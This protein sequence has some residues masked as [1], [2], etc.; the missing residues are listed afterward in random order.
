MPPVRPL[1]S[2]AASA[3]SFALLAACSSLPTIAPD[4]AEAAGTGGVRIDGAH[5]PLS[6]DAQKRVLA[7]LQAAGQDT[8]IF[9][10][11]LAYE[12]EIVGSP[13][14]AGNR[15]TLLQDGPSTYQALYA[16]MAG[17]KNSIDMES[18]IIE[19]DEVGRRF[20]T[21]LKAAVARGVVVNLVYDSVGSIDTPKAY[22]ED[23]AAHG[24]NTL[25]FNPI[26]PLK[27]KAGWDVNSRDHRKLTIVDGRTAF[28]GGINI[29]SVYSGGSFR[30]HTKYE[31]GHGQKVPWRD[32]DLQI[33]GP[34]VA[35]FQKLF[36]DTW[37]R[38]KGK[39]MASADYFPQVERQGDVVVRAIGG[40]STEPYS[41]IYATLLS[42]VRSSSTS[43]LLANAYFDPDP[44]LM[45]AIKDAAKR[46]VD[47][48]L[49]LPSVS[50]TWLVSAA[51]R[52]HYGELLEAGVKIYE[53]QGALLHSK[54]T[55]I[56]GVWCA[57]GST[58]LDWRSFLHNDEID[59][60][61]LS[62]AF[63]DQMRAAFAN[64]L[65]QSQQLTL[66]KWQSRG[67]FPRLQ[68]W[69]AGMWE[70]WL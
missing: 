5:G 8:D 17:A 13:L 29:S 14:S 63:G 23:L 59:A 42:A 26:D 1:L 67:L 70:Y 45:G 68:E 28:V 36:M 48:Q 31:P 18:Y 19:D 34:V 11:H 54:T 12:Q 22:F 50:D 6:P 51:G 33:D 10:R 46:G 3:C 61:V 60:I 15:V 38:Q 53:R 9:Q 27:A 39:A 58:N 24:V 2:R 41:Q 52:R 35:D 64:D 4:T 25:Q 69:S 43:I 66:D 62:P 40:T 20:A 57:V 56:D 37:A 49:L 47:V 16:A 7:R 21:E 65:A 32:T 55:L 30:Q 44:Q